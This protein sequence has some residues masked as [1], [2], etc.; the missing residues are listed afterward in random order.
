MPPRKRR[1][2]KKAST[3]TTHM[4][5]ASFQE[6]DL[7]P[8]GR[9]PMVVLSIDVGV[10]NLAMC[11]V[12]YCSSQWSILH[13]SNQSVIEDTSTR[14]SSIVKSSK[15][16]CTKP[17]QFRALG[18]GSLEYC[19]VHAKAIT[20]KV[21]IVHSKKT[22]KNMTDY[23]LVQRILVYLAKY[24][25]DEWVALLTHVVIERQPVRSR[26]IN[27]VADA[28]FVYWTQCAPMVIFV[29][30]IHKIKTCALS[31]V[32]VVH[33]PKG[34]KGYQLRKSQSVTVTMEIIELMRLRNALN[35]SVGVEDFV[36]SQCGKRD[37]YADTFMQAL[38][39]ICRK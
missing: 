23:E 4:V 32:P 11:V 9:R 13:W 30:A 37:D 39:F 27:L 35:E 2:N 1:F 34:R 6:A 21:A 7:C 33:V 38:Y 29:P 25:N 28:L 10:K 5:N 22:M 17:A 26:K 31:T 20:P 14:C 16:Q 3:A 15:E 24:A 12:E 36:N 8:K 19:G 18:E